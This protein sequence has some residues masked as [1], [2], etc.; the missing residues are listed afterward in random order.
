MD[1]RS[2]LRCAALAGSAAGLPSWGCRFA[3]G[4]AIGKVAWQRDGGS[5]L[6]TGVSVDGRPLVEQASPGLLD[7]SCRLAGGSGTGPLQVAIQHR[8]LDSGTGMGEDV[9]EGTL[10]VRNT[11]DR[12][13]RAEVE[14]AT[15]AGSGN[16]RIYVPLSYGD[17]RFAAL[18]SKD[19]LKDCS[20]LVGASDFTAHYLEP[21]ASYS[22]ERETRALLLAPVV[23]VFD[24]QRPWR[25]ALFTA[26]D[27]SMR[28]SHRGVTW[29]AGRQVTVAAGGTFTQRCWLMVHPGDAS[30]AWRAFQR[31]AHH[32]DFAV[33]GW[34]RA[35]KVH[36]YDFLSSAAGEKGRRGDGYESDLPHFREFRV[37]L[38]TQHGCYA[39]IGD[40]IQPDRTTWQAMRGDRQGAAEMSFEKMRARIKA[41]HAA[42]AKAAVYMHPACFDDAA[43]CFNKLR[44]AVLIDAEG[45][46]TRYFW[47]GPDTVGK[48]WRTSLGSPQWREHLLQQAEWIMDILQPDAI[49]VDE[50]FAGIAYDHHPDRS[51]PT[52]AGAI[53][54]YRKLRALVRS[55]GNDKAVFTSDCSMSPFVL[56]ADGE[57]G[58]HAYPPLLGH[59]LYTQEPVRYLAAL[60]DKPWRPCAWHFQSMWDTQMKLARQVDAGVGVSN[61]WLEYTGLT[62]LSV[63]VKSKMLADIATLF[64]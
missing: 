21:M 50:T 18:G 41:T 20:Q 23:D 49:V 22:A 27:Q 12:P 16:E 42:G 55:F 54:F 14:F 60:S 33:P 8:L 30:V 35:F 56:W 63:E 51:G 19:F 43:P 11:S 2:F 59:S 25:V 44:D 57:C 36:Y 26:S 32:E 40:F 10:T 24:S 64:T 48:N 38:A 52:S 5:R 39:T 4:A 34:A 47:T 58:D 9:L 17:S 31:F 46:P 61:G 3:I 53:D 1:R 13:Q 15:S 7:A 45:E 29:R 62:R 28:F 6:F 37:G